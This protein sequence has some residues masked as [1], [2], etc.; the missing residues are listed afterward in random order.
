M[1]GLQSQLMNKY[2]SG[3]NHRYINVNIHVQGGF[4]TGIFSV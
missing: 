2:T 1:L 3:R 4:E